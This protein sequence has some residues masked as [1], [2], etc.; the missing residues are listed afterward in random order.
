MVGTRLD[1]GK[2]VC[3]WSGEEA[4]EYQVL[5]GLGTSL[6]IPEGCPMEKGTP[7]K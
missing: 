4:G 5:G 3:R 6:P 2:M 1:I 7:A